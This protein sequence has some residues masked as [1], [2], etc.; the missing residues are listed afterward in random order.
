LD[1]LTTDLQILQ[2]SFDSL[3]TSSLL[4]DT[5]SLAELIT[6]LG[7]LT[8]GVLENISGSKK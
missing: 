3:F 4:F 1:P 8:V 6:S 2:D 7:Q 5:Q